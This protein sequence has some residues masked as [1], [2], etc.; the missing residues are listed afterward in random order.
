[1]V[2]IAPLKKVV[3]RYFDRYALRYWEVLECSHLFAK[4]TG[5]DSK[6]HFSSLAYRKASKRRCG[7][8]E[9]IKN[10]NSN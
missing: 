7:Y 10:E 3:S 2:K 9:D 4:W 6:V 5:V 1:M 8:C